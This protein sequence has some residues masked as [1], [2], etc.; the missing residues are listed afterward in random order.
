MELNP[1]AA[2][3]LGLLQLGPVPTRGTPP[4]PGPHAM[5]GWD[6]NETAAASI[7]HFWN[8]TRSQVHLELRR[9]AEQHL[10]EVVGPPGT[11]DRQ[12]Y[13]ITQ[14]GQQAFTQ[15]LER[16]VDREPTRDLL[17]SPLLL[18]VTFGDHLPPATLARSLLSH[19][20][21]AERRLAELRRML[22][23][24]PPEYLRS[25]ATA[26]LRFE[27]AHKELLSHWIGDLLADLPDPTSVPT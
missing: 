26:T 1:T 12:P 13:Q 3:I 7:G 17:R 15:W 16:W 11:R 8:I 24:I 22:S 4:I 20:L 10:V 6:I 27:I 14:A 23:A 5:T 25:T 21:R 9:L 2:S 18:T 19:R